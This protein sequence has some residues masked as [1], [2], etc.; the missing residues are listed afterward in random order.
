MTPALPRRETL[1][2][3]AA[4]L[5]LATSSRAQPAP[6]D[7]RGTVYEETP[8]GRRGLPGIMV[9]NG[10]QI[11]LTGPDG[12][13]RIP[14]A[15]GE[16]VFVVKPTGWT[17]PADPATGLPA[18]ARLHS[19]A[20][21]PASLGLRF[22]GVAPTGKLPP[23]IDFALRRQDELT[24]FDAIL[25]TDPQPESEVELGHVRDDVVARL[26]GFSAAFG[27]G[28]GDL[29]FD[30]LAFYDRYNRMIGT[31]G[32]P[33]H[34]CPGNHDMNYEAP[35]DALSRE[36]FKRVF[37]ARH[38]AFQH[39]GATFFLLDNVEYLGTDPARPLSNGGYR[40]RFGP[41]QLAFVRNVLAHVPADSRSSSVT[42]SRSTRCRAP[43]PPTST[44]TRRTSSPPSP[45]TRTRSASPATPTPTS[46]GI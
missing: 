8:T 20:G 43:N 38:H 29:M 39:G 30:D 19:P 11:V 6:P 22:P 12:A 28:L 14:L 9:S 36:T 41:R 10:E 32:I 4:S 44:P 35:D 34:N 33:W 2:G 31:S 5:A 13:W 7:A 40:G 42:T 16:S 21:T 17:T 15:E 27:L 46:T 1:I 37:G 26:A 24:R 18:F 25:L 3:A 23:G 45:R